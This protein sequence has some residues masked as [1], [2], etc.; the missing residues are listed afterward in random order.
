MIDCLG[1][2]IKVGDKVLT[3]AYY[4]TNMSEITT[5]VK[6]NKK[7]VVVEIEA[8]A[9]KVNPDTNKWE[10]K[11]YD[12]YRIR[13]HPSKVIVIGAQLEHNRQNYPECMI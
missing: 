12:N 5:V 8:Y 11:Q 9:Y 4:S 1:H 13:R 10:G 3:N 2:P 6:I 7:S